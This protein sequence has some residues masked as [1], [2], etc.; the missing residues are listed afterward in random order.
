MSAG[1]QKRVIPSK[2][3]LIGWILQPGMLDCVKGLEWG[4][5]MTTVR[6]ELAEAFICAKCDYHGAHV[7]RLSMSGTG[8][9]RFLDVQPYRYVFASCQNCGYTEVFNLRMLESKDDL[10]MF[11]DILFAS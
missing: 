6:N 1:R 8:F 9:S 11:L 3:N 2:K 10:G 7:E 4:Y 5:G